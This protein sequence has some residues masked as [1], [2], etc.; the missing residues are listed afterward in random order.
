M[1]QFAGFG[2]PGETNQR[3]KRLIAQGGTGLSVAFDLPTLYGIDSDN[4]LANGEVGRAGVSIDTVGDMDALFEGIDLSTTSVSMTINS[5]AAPVLAMFMVSALNRGFSPER[6]TGTVQ[7]DILKEFQAQK[8]FVFP[9]RPSMR[10]VT[11]MAQYMDS[12]MPSWHPISISGYHIREAGST[13]L[14][15]LAFTL[16][17]GFAYVEAATAR[18]MDIDDFAP[19]LSFFFNSH[20]DFFEEIAKFRAARRL[21]ASWLRDRYNAKLPKSM[22]LRFHCQTSGAS[23]TAQQPE[24]NMSRVAIEALAAVLGGTQS[25]HTDAFDEALAL[26]TEHAATLALRTQQVIAEE[27]GAA[28]VADPLGGSWYVETLTNDM[29]AE[30]EVILAGI[31]EAGTGSMLQGVLALIEDGWFC[32]EISDSAFRLE[33]QISSNGRV[34][35]GVNDYCESDSPRPAFHRTDPGS[36]SSQI[37]S[38]AVTKSMRNQQSVDKALCAVRES[39]SDPNANM[40]PSIVEA[41]SACATVGEIMSALQSVFGTY[42]DAVAI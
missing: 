25:L 39:A 10:L 36:E 14:Q 3:F 37:A 13:A 22:Q 32:S 30:A 8:E 31:A 2:T 16:A 9:P 5:S 18:G 21:W 26:P 17:N 42:E 41:A 19:K 38:L 15:E 29:V 27:T 7:N 11:D 6:L 24:V 34:Q 23:L 33:S 35:V 1:R 28:D 20:I 4:P 40:M 12:A